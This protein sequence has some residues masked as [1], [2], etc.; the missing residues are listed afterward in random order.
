MCVFGVCWW[1]CLYSFVIIVLLAV[2]IYV[3]FRCY[4]ACDAVCFCL[5][6][7]LGDGILVVAVFT[8]FVYLVCCIYFSLYVFV[9]GFVLLCLFGF[10]VV[11]FRLRLVVCVGCVVLFCVWLLGL[12]AFT[13]FCCV[14]W[15]PVVVSLC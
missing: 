10:A 6:C 5:V 12:V 2:V 14:G 15:F 11:S 4:F 8:W 13:W 3:C 1:A 7:G 9:V